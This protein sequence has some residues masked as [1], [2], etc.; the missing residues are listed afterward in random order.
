MPANS[1]PTNVANIFDNNALGLHRQRAKRLYNRGKT[2]S[3]DFLLKHAAE[4]IASR[5]SLVSRQF[6]NSTAI[7]GRTEVVA[8]AMSEAKNVAKVSR[9]EDDAFY[10]NSPEF[11]TI[12]T[13]AD[14][15]V[16]PSKLFDLAVSILAPHW[17][18]NLPGLLIQIKNLIQ[19]DGLFLGTLAGPDTL[20]ELRECMAMAEVEIFGGISPRVDPFI[21]VQSAG[22]LMQRAG[23]A[24]PVIDSDKIIVRYDTFFD[25]VKDLRAMAATN[26]LRTREKRKYSKILFTRAAEIYASRFAD[27]DGRIRATF[28]LIS[29]SGWVPHP[30][31]QK[32]MKPGSAKIHLADALNKSKT[33]R[34]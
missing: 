30:S 28:E 19:P 32:P 34:E 15:L 1:S 9:I 10:S 13:R 22:A 5:I 11:P 25:L 33:G 3:P 18:A 27:N 16:P 7:F 23:F 20:M 29:I 24:L 21:T 26:A 6:E 8:S 4:D 14:T 12:T 2:T 17:S 31:Q